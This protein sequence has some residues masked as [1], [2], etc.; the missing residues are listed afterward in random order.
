MLESIVGAGKVFCYAD[1]VG[2][3]LKDMQLLPRLH[4]VFAVSASAAGLQ[5]KVSKC[6]LLPPRR[7]GPLIAG[8]AGP[9]P[10]RSAE[11]RPGMGRDV[12]AAHGAILGY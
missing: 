4:G 8:A 10:R 3:L 11:D 2:V 12:G 5:L 1:N 7:C 6:A 9:L